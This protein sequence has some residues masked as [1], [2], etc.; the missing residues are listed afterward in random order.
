VLD[1]GAILASGTGS[2]PATAPGYAKENLDIFD[3]ALTKEEVS[4]LDALSP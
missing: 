3:F 1:R 4:Y 2:N